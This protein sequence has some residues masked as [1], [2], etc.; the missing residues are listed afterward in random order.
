MKVGRTAWSDRDLEIVVG[1]ILRFGV[2][3]S[4]A[5]VS[6]GGF[7]YLWRHGGEPFGAGVFRGE[8]EYFRTVPGILRSVLAGRGRGIIQLGLLMLIA[9]PVARVAFAAAGFALERDR[10]YVVVA[11]LV[12][13]LLAYSLAGHGSAPHHV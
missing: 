8:P 6:V 13:A 7:I 2:S 4:A 3:A 10:L 12:L 9:T 5:V 1:N 11:L